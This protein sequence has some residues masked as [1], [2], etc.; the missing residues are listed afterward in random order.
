MTSGIAT[1][2]QLGKERP[3]EGALGGACLYRKRS[4]SRNE[5]EHRPLKAPRIYL[6]HAATTPVVE[7]ARA[8]MAEALERWANPSSPHAEGRAA[9]AALE[10]ARARI[11]AALGWHGALIFTSGASEALAIALARA[12]AGRRFIS[13]VEHDAVRRGAPGAGVIPVSAEG[14]VDPEASGDGGLVAVQ[15]VNNETGVIQP[16]GPIAEAVR[17]AGGLLLAD[18]AQS[19]GRLPLPDVDLIALSAHK[20]GGPP[21]IGAL[22][23]RDLATIEASGGQ[24]QGYRAGTENLPAALG[25]AAALEAAEDWMERAGSLR[26]RLEAALDA[27]GGEVVARDAPRLPTIGSY[28]MPGVPSNAQLI[29]FDL[30]GIAV[31]AGSACSSGSIR[32]SHVLA[33]MGW[34][35]DRAREVVRVSFGPSISTEDV[36][37]FVEA[38]TAISARAR[39]RAA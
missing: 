32:P 11:K 31:S 5:L 27:A 7:P 17:G 26:L 25:F 28:R 22:L 14:L 30:A 21:G 36:D 9:R 24:E 6:D 2:E 1:C 34:S 37:R 19:A 13:A 33:A 18:C 38:W 4:S 39:S 15:A 29:A 35:E 3:R 8:A 20:L 12:K 23:V 10:D 16:L